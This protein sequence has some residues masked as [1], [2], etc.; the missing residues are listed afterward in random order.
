MFVHTCSV[1]ESRQLVFPSQIEALDNTDHGIIVSFTCWC[2][3]EQSLLT[4]RYATEPRSGTE[5]T[6]A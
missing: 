4:G 5:A 2:G 1:C 3:A 6:A